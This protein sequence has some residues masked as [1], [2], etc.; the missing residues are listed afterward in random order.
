[1]RSY[2]KNKPFNKDVI[3]NNNSQATNKYD[4]QIKKNVYSK[5]VINYRSNKNEEKN[6]SFATKDYS[7]NNDFKPIKTDNRQEKTKID[8]HGSFKGAPNLG[9]KGTNNQGIFRKENPKQNK[10]MVNQEVKNEAIKKIS[11]NE[12]PS[13]DNLYSRKIPIGNAI[14]KEKKIINNQ[15]IY[16]QYRANNINSRETGNNNI[17]I[18]NEDNN[19]RMKIN[20]NNNNRQTENLNKKENL[21]EKKLLMIKLI[22]KNIHIIKES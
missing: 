19:K 22:K 7:N 15:K 4:G 9:T 1:M 11:S 12:I 3:T 18:K 5:R 20:N 2:Y 21:K 16:N 6:R 17:A 8:Y 10:I 13:K 14:D